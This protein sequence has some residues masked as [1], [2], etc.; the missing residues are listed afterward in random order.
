[1]L[2]NPQGKA[3]FT[4]AVD[5]GMV[6]RMRALRQRRGYKIQAMANDALR[7]HLDALE[8][9]EARPVQAPARFKN[10]RKNE[11]RV[12]RIARLAEA[13]IR[14]YKLAKLAERAEFLR[15]QLDARRAATRA[16]RCTTL[17]KESVFAAVK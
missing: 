9:L 17:S 5:P 14:A 4:V 16:K 12:V 8:G 15:A 6:T 1:M 11:L 7:A 13:K 3:L 2:L 10:L